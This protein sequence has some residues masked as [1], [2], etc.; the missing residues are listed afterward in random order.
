MEA[1]RDAFEDIGA[2][3]GGDTPAGTDC[4]RV[5][6]DGD[7]ASQ[8]YGTAAPT[9]NGSMPLIGGHVD[10]VAAELEAGGDART[11]TALR[12][13]V[14]RRNGRLYASKPREAESECG[15]LWRMLAFQLSAKPEH[16]CMPV[17][18]DLGLGPEYRR[19]ESAEE[20]RKRHQARRE[21]CRQLDAVGGKVA[22]RV[23]AR[24]QHGILRWARAMGR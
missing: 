10:A 16:H 2:G 23:P 22:D 3:N 20:T 13:V 5:V 12:G 21:R 15:Y 6:L 18:A 14:N 11:A 1:R 19:G 8:G 24:Q 17:T 7:G 4:R 9:D